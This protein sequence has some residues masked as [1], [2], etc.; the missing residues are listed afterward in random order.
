MDSSFKLI[1]LFGGATLFFGGIY[2]LAGVSSKCRSCQ[3][4]F[5]I[6]LI[7]KEQLKI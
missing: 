6:K 5:A 4:W 2:C 7:K 1:A 3:E